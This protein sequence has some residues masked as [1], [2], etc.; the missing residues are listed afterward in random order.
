MGTDRDRGTGG[1]EGIRVAVLR[2]AIEHVDEPRRRVGRPWLPGHHV[3][4][5][6]HPHRVEA[7]VRRANNVLVAGKLLGR[8]RDEGLHAE[9]CRCP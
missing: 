1:V 9:M 3:L 8:A 6:H 7:H 5:P 4:E 2:G